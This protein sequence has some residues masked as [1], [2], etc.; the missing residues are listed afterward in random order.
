MPRNKKQQI[1]RADARRKLQHTLLQV[2][3][4]SVAA[5]STETA[6]HSQGND[7]QLA[8]I[9][10]V[11]TAVASIRKKSLVLYYCVMLQME[12]S[13]RI[14]EVLSIVPND[15]SYWGEIRIKTKKG[16][17][18]RLISPNSCREYML[19]CKHLDISPFADL[20]E[21]AVYRAYKAAGLRKRM[22]G[23]KKDTVTHIF[24]HLTAISA[25]THDFG[26]SVI[27]DKLGHKSSKSQE[28]YGK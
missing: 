11:L 14:S 3:P 15:I 16:G 6:K 20:N 27:S 19:K 10:T 12:Y 1:Q 24:R 21:T 5:P 8:D 25:R 23:R 26:N 2:R 7:A 4:K 17:R 9:S 28:H 13:L 18:D 22:P